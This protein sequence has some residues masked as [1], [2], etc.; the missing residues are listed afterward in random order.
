MLITLCFT[1]YTLHKHLPL[2]VRLLLIFRKENGQSVC[3]KQRKNHDWFSVILSQ[4]WKQRFQKP[5]VWIRV[6]KYTYIY[7]FFFSDVLE[8]KWLNMLTFLSS[9]ANK[10]NATLSF[11]GISCLYHQVHY[12]ENW[13]GKAYFWELLECILLF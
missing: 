3:D 11:F 13:N 9:I 5:K 4:F 10:F 12:L 2:V 1:D 7:I 6:R 8:K